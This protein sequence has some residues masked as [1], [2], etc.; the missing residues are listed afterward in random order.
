MKRAG[1]ELRWTY[2]EARRDLESTNDE[3]WFDSVDSDA[4]KHEINEEGQ[5][6]ASYVRGTGKSRDANQEVQIGRITKIWCI[7]KSGDDSS[8]SGE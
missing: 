3:V 8:L 7:L 1:F 2:L 6:N 4:F 5:V